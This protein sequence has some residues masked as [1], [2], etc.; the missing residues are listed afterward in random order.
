VEVVHDATRRRYEALLDGEP[1]GHATYTPAEGAV[2]IGH[3]EVDRRHE[4]RGVGAAIIEAAL[5]DLRARGLK[6]LPL[7]SFAAAFVR[8]H[9]EYADLVPEDRKAQFR[10]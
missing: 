7:C 3:T 2:I 4:G 10:L 5:D 8:R 1:V 9:P 6:V